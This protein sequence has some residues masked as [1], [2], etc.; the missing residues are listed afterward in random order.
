MLTTGTK[1]AVQNREY[2]LFRLI[3][4]PKERQNGG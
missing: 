1:T 2:L 4:K 3:R